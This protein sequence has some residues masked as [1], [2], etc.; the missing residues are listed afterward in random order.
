GTTLSGTNVV[1][2]AGLAPNATA[3]FTVAPRNNLDSGWYY[4]VVAISFYADLDIDFDCCCDIYYYF[5]VGDVEQV[6]FV[7]FY[8]LPAFSID[9]PSSFDENDIGIAGISATMSVTPSQ[10]VG[11]GQRV[12]V[13]VTFDG[14]PEVYGGLSLILLY[15]TH[16]FISGG[17]PVVVAGQPIDDVV[18]DFYMGWGDLE[19]TLEF[20]FHEMDDSYIPYI[21]EDLDFWIYHMEI[22]TEYYLV[23]ST[24]GNDVPHWY[25]W[26]TQAQ[27]NA[28]VSAINEV[29]S[30]WQAF[31]DGEDITLSQ[32]LNAMN[33]VI[34]IEAA[35]YGQIQYGNVHDLGPI[36]VNG[37]SV[38]LAEA[39]SYDGV[40]VNVAH[41]VTSVTVNVGSPWAEHDDLFINGEP[42][43]FG[44]NQ[45]ISLGAAGTVTTITLRVELDMYCPY[46]CGYDVYAI[47]TIRVSRAAAPV[48][49]PDNGQ[50][51]GH[52]PDPGPGPGPGPGAPAPAPAPAPDVDDPAPGPG[53]EVN[54]EIAIGEEELIYLVE[55]DE[56]FVIEQ[57]GVTLVIPNEILAAIFDAENPEDITVEFNVSPVSDADFEAGHLLTVEVN[58][59]VGDEVI[60]VTATPFTVSVSLE[61]F[62]L[63]DV[64]T[65]R[66]IAITED[67]AIIGGRLDPETGLFTFETQITGGF[68]ISYVEDLI[69]LS[70]S[71][72]SPVIYD[73][74]ANAPT[75]QMDVLPV[76]QD[77]RTLIPIRFIAETLGAEVDWTPATADTPLTI[78][79][80]LD[81][82][83]LTFA[84][85]EI[86]PGL[87]ALGMDVPAQIM[88]GRTMVPL[89]FISEFFGAIVTWDAE[90]RG[91]EIVK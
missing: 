85:G 21:M 90:T 4:A 5:Y 18:L 15:N 23:V 74:A 45:T 27:M 14:V 89:R 68:T 33:T 78:H 10:S 38:N 62:D 61:D 6:F 84:I 20:F 57:E 86:T 13:T 16:Y 28:L 48:Q 50:Q 2:P 67:G 87:A 19:L 41:N 37:V 75:Q 31:Y 83:I 76:I 81:G 22:F 30:V 80:A 65:Y 26:I 29:R 82:Q 11:P 53:P 72:D 36:I 73:L 58:I 44:V 1:I 56:D 8:V 32:A 42:A 54:E 12:A 3:T 7:D 63:G 35:L 79:V 77:G 24:D 64:N 49:Q 9:Y 40:T 47:Y 34:S 17:W 55:Q 88:D 59:S 70:L 39:R 91:I 43:E 60:E 52:T 46:C 71:L 69:R 25:Q 51:P 66:I